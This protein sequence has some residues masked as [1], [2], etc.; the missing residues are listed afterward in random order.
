MSDGSSVEQDASSA[1]A[2]ADNSSTENQETQEQEKLP[3]ELP[4]TISHQ[5]L[6]L[7]GSAFICFELIFL[8]MYFEQSWF[9][10]DLI[11]YGLPSILCC[12]IFAHFLLLFAESN[13]SCRWLS[14]IFKGKPPVAYKKWLRLEDDSIV[15]GIKH[16]RWEA[17]DELELTFMGNLVVKSRL[18]CGSHSKQPD[19]VLKFPFGIADFATQ[20]R[21]LAIAKQKKKQIEFNRRLS[22]GR[23]TN[24]QKGAQATQLMTAG[25]MTLLLLDVGFSS[26]YY[27]ELLKNYYLAEIDLLA[28]QTKDAN[29]HFVR[30]ED[31][32]QHPLP[33]SWVSA[34][35]LGSSN[36]AA[37]IW[38]QR[39]RIL[40]LQNKKEEALEDSRKAVKESPSNLRH[41]LYLTRLLVETNN[42]SEARENLEKI[43]EEHKHSFM[44]RLYI[45]AITKSQNNNAPRIAQE[46]KTQLDACYEDTYDA[47]PHWPPGGNRY[48]MELFY[49]DDTRFLLDRFLGTTYNRPKAIPSEQK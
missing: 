38:E 23:A 24:L 29:L 22:K 43:L 41:R 31:L 30:A 44:P 27:L 21:F 33:F 7:V 1:S 2:G 48:F 20:D 46:Y 40:W 42:L 47:E 12:V 11:A 5:I 3:L 10:V 9:P 25:I 6:T 14:F 16:L 32:R 37:G 49:S 28:G 15:Y 13:L 18:L 17:L 35:F 19:K 8:T 45:L 34:K 36:V 39:S 4:T 26:F